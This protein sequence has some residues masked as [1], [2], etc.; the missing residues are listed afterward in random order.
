MSDGFDD[1]DDYDG[2]IVDDDP[3]LDCILYEEMT[4][5]DKNRQNGGGCLGVVILLA[6]L[7]GGVLWLAKLSIS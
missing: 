4:K 2:I 1:Y 5:E 6:P 3:A 7:A